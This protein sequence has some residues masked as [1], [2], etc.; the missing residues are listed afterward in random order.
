MSIKPPT[1]E[2]SE[3]D[4]KRERSQAK[5]LRSYAEVFGTEDKKRT[6]AQKLVMADMEHRG[7]IH[8]TTLVATGKDGHS[9]AQFN[10]S[11]EG[12]RLFMLNT[13]T[14]IQLGAKALTQDDEETTTTKRQTIKRQST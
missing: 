7:Y 6:P 8:R 12:Q 3:E 5:L 9:D 4:K 14:L 11:A 1:R 13:K 10:A 2:P